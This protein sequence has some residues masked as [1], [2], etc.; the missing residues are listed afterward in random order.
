MSC[1]HALLYLNQLF[2]DLRVLAFVLRNFVR[3]GMEHVLASYD[4]FCVYSSLSREVANICGP[5]ISH[6]FCT[7]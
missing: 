2:F 6:V 1:R 3:H 5:K 7:V 4:T